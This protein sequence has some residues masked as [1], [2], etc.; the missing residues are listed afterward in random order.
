M[1]SFSSVSITCVVMSVT[2]IAQVNN[3]PK[4]VSPGTKSLSECRTNRF[5]KKLHPKTLN[6]V[7]YIYNLNAGIYFIQHTMVR[8]GGN[9]Q[10]GKK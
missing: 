5:F 2:I 7:T 6:L 9:G 3:P 1:D 4:M 10:P 8:G